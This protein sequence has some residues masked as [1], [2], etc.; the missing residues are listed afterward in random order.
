MPAQNSGRPPDLIGAR[1]RSAATA[2]GTSQNVVWNAAINNPSTEDAQAAENA[3]VNFL[4]RRH[5]V[6]PAVAKIIVSELRLGGCW[7]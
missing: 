4:V 5:F 7:S 3:A 6:R 2:P 1:A